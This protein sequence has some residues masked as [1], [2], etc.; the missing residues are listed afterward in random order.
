MLAGADLAITAMRLVGQSAGQATVAVTLT[1]QGVEPTLG[2]GGAG[3]FGADLYVKP[4]GGSPP[5]GPGDRYLGYCPAPGNYCPG[6]ER[7]DLYR[8]TKVYD[9]GGLAPGESWVLTY[10]FVLSAGSRYWVYAQADTFWGANGDPD[11]TLFGSSEHG[12]IVEVN[13]LNNI[14]SRLEVQVHWKVYLPLVVKNR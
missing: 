2:P 9:G 1:N 11:P 4:V 13:E 3:W 12:R 14:S 5:F 7:A 6:S 8:V 10:T